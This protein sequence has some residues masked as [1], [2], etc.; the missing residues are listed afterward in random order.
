MGTDETWRWRRNVGERYFTRM[1]GQI[2]LR[3]GLPRLL[4]ASQ[5]TQLVTDKKAYVSGERITISG[6]L[7]R[8]GLDPVTD[9]TVA[10]AIE[11]K[12]DS[13]GAT[14]ELKKEVELRATPGKPG[15]YQ[16][17][18]MATTPG[19]YTFS[20]STDSTAK[21]DFQVTQPRLEFGDTALNVKLL[22]SMAEASGG[23]FYREEDLY[24]LP[25]ILG[26]KTDKVSSPA[27]FEIFFMP[28]YFALMMVIATVEWILR[29]LWKLK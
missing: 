12:P 11:I 1:W 17:E 8:S 15:F 25:D 22:K 23:A 28:V 26:N 18:I 2:L 9:Q 21:L 16:G 3:L 4:G 19:V 6:K 5:L 27:E 20:S 14:G 13:A 24:K 29:K 10:G 7:Y